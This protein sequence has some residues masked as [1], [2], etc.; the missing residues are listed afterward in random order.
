NPRCL[1]AAETLGVLSHRGAPPE[2]LPDL[3][4]AAISLAQ[5]CSRLQLLVAYAA[6]VLVNSRALAAD[7]WLAQERASAASEL[8]SHVPAGTAVL[9][10]QLDEVDLNALVEVQG[11][12]ET[13]AIDHDP[14]PPKFST[15]VRLRAFDG[16]AVVRVRAHMFSL[17]KNG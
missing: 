3:G 17:E 8:A 12:I 2:L 6:H 16:G 1:V 9:I 15:F 5:A 11:R 7:A 13:L 14:A 10:G 4:P